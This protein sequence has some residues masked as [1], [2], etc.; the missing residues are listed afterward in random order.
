[1]DYGLHLGIAFQLVD[2]ALDYGANNADL[3][4]NIG[5]DL[6]EGKPTLP[7]I[8]AMQAGNNAQRALIKET[9]ENGG[10]EHIEPILA[11]IES[12]GAIDYTLALARVEADAAK[13]AISILPPSLPREALVQLADFAVNRTY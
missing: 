11:A 9:I 3:G 4:K 6:A 8:R 12:T 13:G 5:D 2:D 1:V 10:R 7:L